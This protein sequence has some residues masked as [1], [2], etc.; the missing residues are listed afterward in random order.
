LIKVK[1]IVVHLLQKQK[2][3]I[4]GNVSVPAMKIPSIKTSVD[5]GLKKRELNSSSSTSD[6]KKKKKGGINFKVNISDQV[7]LLDHQRKRNLIF[8][9]FH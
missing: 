6:E 5:I 2:G 3:E 4:E 7:P 9:L 8:L 1:L